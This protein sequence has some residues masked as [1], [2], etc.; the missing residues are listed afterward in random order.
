MPAW[1]RCSLSLMARGC[2]R[3][4]AGGPVDVVGAELGV[5]GGTVIGT[6]IGPCW[7]WPV[8]LVVV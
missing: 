3:R 6:S 8:A 7:G 1:L 2:S 4:D 5:S